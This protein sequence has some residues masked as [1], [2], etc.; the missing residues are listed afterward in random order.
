MR[1]VR[2]LGLLALGLALL[3]AIFHDVLLRRHSRRPIEEQ[4]ATHV[5]CLVTPVDALVLPLGSEPTPMHDF[6]SLA[7]LARYLERPIL[8]QTD[9]TG[10]TYAV[11]DET[12]YFQYRAAPSGQTRPE[13]TRSA[14]A[15]RPR[16]SVGRRARLTIGATLLALAIA[17]TLV[18]SF[19][20]TTNV[21][22]SNVGAS[23][24]AKQVSQL[25]PA[26][27]SSLSLT[28]LVIH[29][30]DFTNTASHALVL[31]DASTET[32]TDNGDHN[33]IVGGGGRDTVKGDSTDICIIGP[34][35]GTSYRKCSTSS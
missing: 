31:G 27:C 10:S 24:H 21:P 35:S 3:I 14:P 34:S 16:R 23:S 11:D 33:C 9:E 1:V 12:R 30:G 13:G 29:S 17:I 28:T 26:G 4:I 25:A 19:T 8:R 18:T 7:L 22:A 32:I 2:L 5:G 6:M 20:S 15:I